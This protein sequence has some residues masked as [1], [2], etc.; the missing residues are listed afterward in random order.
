LG[1]GSPGFDE[2]GSFGLTGDV[3]TV[4][5][6]SVGAAGSFGVGGRHVRDVTA[7]VGSTID[8]LSVRARR[9]ENFTFRAANVPV[10]FSARGVEVNADVIR[11]LDLDLGYANSEI[12][13]MALRMQ[14][15]QVAAKFADSVSFIAE[16]FMRDV[17]LSIDEARG[18][19][20]IVCGYA[21]AVRSPR[22][23][24]VSIALG[25]GAIGAIDIN[26]DGDIRDVSIT[27]AVSGENGFP[28]VTIQAG[29]GDQQDKPARGGSIE[30]VRIDAAGQA[31]DGGSINIFAGNGGATFRGGSV[32]N[33]RFDAPLVSAQIIAGFG[34]ENVEGGRVGDGGSIREISGLLAA[35]QLRAGAG[36]EG[37]NGGSGGTISRVS[38][39]AGDISEIIA[40][41]GG[42][43]FKR[44]GDGGSVLSI[45][46]PGEI[47]VLSAGEAGPRLDETT[48]DGIRGI[49]RNI[50][51][52]NL[53]VP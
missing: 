11:G 49:V 32:S 42:A 43:G 3:E 50:S 36:G 14:G 16:Q 45:S 17:A 39:A 33:I 15:V 9:V 34:G 30:G 19:I 8:G 38:L 29:H 51:S 20:A 26:S 28:S 18:G 48:K 7:E 22:I 12:S 44:A 52:A 27:R 46:T 53:V 25:S 4:R 31:A 24:G 10:D 21:G 5:V 1:G 6:Y 47:D 37:M 23:D 41:S 13:V 2:N 35:L 40:G